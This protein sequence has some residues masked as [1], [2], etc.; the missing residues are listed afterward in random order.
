MDSR[1]VERFLVIGIGS[2]LMRD[3]GVGP[4]LADV[5]GD[6]LDKESVRVIAAETDVAF[7]LA[8]IRPADAV[9]LLDAVLTGGR[10]GDVFLYKL[11][12]VQAERD[13]FSLHDVSL[14]SVLKEEQRCAFA[15][16]IGIEA[17][18][19]EPGYGLSPSLADEFGTIAE[20]V[21]EKIR[22]VKEQ[23]ADEAE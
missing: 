11:D 2:R 20:S 6:E 3:D 17:A 7:G 1:P 14:I 12:D 23:I 18:C 4:M 8:A 13:A 16:L 22:S 10:P 15:C 19:I 9:I 21:M 5:L